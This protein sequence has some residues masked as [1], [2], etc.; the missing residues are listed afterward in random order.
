MS[1]PAWGGQ[2]MLCQQREESPCQIFARREDICF[3]EQ[4]TYGKA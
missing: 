1:K 3:K 4:Q 2:G